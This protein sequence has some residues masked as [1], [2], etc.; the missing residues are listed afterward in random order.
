MNSLKEAL[1]NL[2]TSFDANTSVDNELPNDAEISRCWG[3][4]SNEPCEICDGRGWYVDKGSLK[5][6]DNYSVTRDEHL[7]D[8]LM[9]K[10]GLNEKKTFANFYTAS[11]VTKIDY[12]DG[13]RESLLNALKQSERFAKKPE[14]W[15]VLQGTY[16]CGKTH[17]ANATASEIMKTKGWAVMFTSGADFLDGIRA[18]FNS[19][20]VQSADDFIRI[21]KE[22][23]LLVL[24]DYGAESPTEWA[25][26]KLFQILNHRHAHNMPT[27]ITTNLS[28]GQMQ[29]RI[30]SRMNESSIVNFIK[31]SAPD[32][33]V[34]TSKMNKS[35]NKS[36]GLDKYKDMTFELFTGNPQSIAKITAEKWAKNPRQVP[37]LYITGYYGIGK[38]YLAASVGNV[39]S[40]DNEVI[41]VTVRELTDEM[42]VAIGKENS[43]TPDSVMKKYIDVEFLILD[44]LDAKSRSFS[45]WSKERLFN[46]ID[47][48]IIS[49]SP[50]VITSIHK[51]DELDSRYKSR[52][53]NKSI[54]YQCIAD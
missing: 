11:S 4:D 3:K 35:K 53:Q 52:L 17:L 23:K 22:A 14:G 8:F 44:D 24:D 15:L 54:C 12:K 39:L 47:Q 2:R 5:K 6:C 41:F 18:T 16:G 34:K 36:I 48:R 29:P 20:S 21:G 13:E 38:T 25:R 1:K 10:S 33:R 50:T 9:S 27:I 32:Y 31:I 7:Q 45:V 40:K 26:E 42:H 19:K 43:D 51:I 37:F 30:R 46:I 49:K 28:L